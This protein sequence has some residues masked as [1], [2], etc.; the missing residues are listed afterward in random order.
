MKSNK[1]TIHDISSALNI[2]SST[3]SRALNDSP[4]VSKKTKEKIAKKAAE[5][6]YQRNSLASN[7]RTNRTNTI[8]VIVP[9][10]SR[11]FFS[12]VI[13]GIEETAYEAGFN[14]VICQSLESIDREKK[15]I[16][17]LLAN[18]VD[19]ILISI[20]METTSYEHLQ[21]YYDHGSPIVFYDRPCHFHNCTAVSIDD[22][23]ASF[24]AT[25]HLIQS[26]RKNIFHFSGPQEIELYQ[27]RKRGYKDALKKH[28]IEV[29][30]DYCHESGLS[31]K[32]GIKAA[33]KIMN[34]KNIDA[35]F[36]ANDT[37]AIGAMKYLKTQGIRIPEDIAVV[38]F[39]NDPISEVIEPSLTTVNQPDFKMGKIAATILLGQ[40]KN[41]KA[42]T[43]DQSIVLNSELIIRNSSIN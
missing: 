37:A 14:V 15:L 4:R 6:G 11:N 18:R 32:E 1:I 27:N 43:K 21:S 7:L 19:G 25:E 31:E 16:E 13:A 12:T 30:E 20:S 34:L 29:N 26:G 2:D 8:G 33:K 41:K 42:D 23:K 22:Y 5:L 36:S 17:T 10:I 24:D 38:G 9:R 28:N 40:I 35:I 3:V 39:N